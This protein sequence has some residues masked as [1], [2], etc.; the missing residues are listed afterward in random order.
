V[1]RLF[2]S[3]KSG[4]VVGMCVVSA[5]SATFIIRMRWFRLRRIA[6]MSDV[7]IVIDRDRDGQ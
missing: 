6:R 1:H 5:W 4:Y 3:N 2:F 7:L